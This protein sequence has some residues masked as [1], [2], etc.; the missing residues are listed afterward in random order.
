MPRRHIAPIIPANEQEYRVYH[1]NLILA[2]IYAVTHLGEA[3]LNAYHDREPLGMGSEKVVYPHLAHTGQVVAFYQNHGDETDQISLSELRKRYFTIKL[4][5]LLLPVNI[6]D[7][8][9]VSSDPPRMHLDMVTSQPVTDGKF[10]ELYRELSN[11]ATVL[12]VSLDPKRNNYL[13]GDDGNLKY[14]DDFGLPADLTDLEAGI[15]KIEAPDIRDRAL[16]YA[17]RA[18]LQLPSFGGSAGSTGL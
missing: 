17:D 3:I 11:R 7:A 9:F 15:Q 12:G 13:L 4:M 10:E 1:G 8:H 14:V 16:K 18:H 6:P 5:H 2:N